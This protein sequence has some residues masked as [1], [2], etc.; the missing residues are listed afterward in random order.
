[1]AGRCRTVLAP[2]NA[3]RSGGLPRDPL[4][5]TPAEGC[6]SQ[7]RRSAHRG[8]V[9]PRAWD[10]GTYG[11]ASLASAHGELLLRCTPTLQGCSFWGHRA[12]TPCVCGTWCHRISAFGVTVS[13]HCI[14]IIWGPCIPTLQIRI[15]RRQG[16]S[17]PRP[18]SSTPR[19]EQTPQIPGTCPHGEK[20]LPEGATLLSPAAG[21]ARLL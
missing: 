17:A 11:H 20:G 15:P 6:S 2:A 12:P 16:C 5:G 19:L 10:R 9:H 7:R 4:P 13:R 14:C 21:R 18:S 1:M 3:A 8:P